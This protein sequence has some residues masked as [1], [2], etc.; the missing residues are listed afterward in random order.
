MSRARDDKGF[1]F[2]GASHAR[3]RHDLSS[4][5]HAQNTC[6]NTDFSKTSGP[7]LYCGHEV[8]RES[9]PVEWGFEVS[10]LVQNLQRSI[11][12]QCSLCGE[13]SLLGFRLVVSLSKGVNK[14]QPSLSEEHLLQTQPNSSNFGIS[15]ESFDLI[16]SENV[17]GV[18]QHDGYSEGQRRV[19]LAAWAASAFA[20]VSVATLLLVAQV[21]ATI[22]PYLVWSGPW[23]CSLGK[24]I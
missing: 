12:L 16:P 20:F 14:I 18:K 1:R 4:P 9:V 11:T 13:V 21:C 5:I 19:A 8:V 24:I 2:F 15:F 23:I 7:T 17:T 10:S 22:N 6:Q 3:I